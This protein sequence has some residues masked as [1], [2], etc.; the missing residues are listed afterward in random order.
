MGLLLTYVY[1][2]FYDFKATIENH[3]NFQSSTILALLQAKL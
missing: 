1:L 3:A 2:L